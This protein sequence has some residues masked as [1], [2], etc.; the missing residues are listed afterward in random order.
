LGFRAL[1]DFTARH[2][3]R[4]DMFA[5]P[6]GVSLHFLAKRMAFESAKCL[7]CSGRAVIVYWSV[8]VFFLDIGVLMHQQNVESSSSCGIGLLL[9]K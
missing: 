7:P 1:G 2:L 9:I 6:L 8:L 5:F 3:V 4:L